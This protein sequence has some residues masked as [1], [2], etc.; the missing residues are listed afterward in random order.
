MGEDS[1]ILFYFFIL[2]YWLCNY[3]CPDFSA[4]APPPPST[5]HSLRPSPHHCSCP[6]VMHVS[7]LATSFPILYF[8]SPLLFSTYL[9]F[10]IPS[11]LHPFPTPLPSDNHQNDLCVHDSV[12]VL[13]CLFCFLDSVVDRYV[14][15]AILLFIVLIFSF[16]NKSC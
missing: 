4:F 1:G 5:L 3:S 15:I 11:L 8:I 10:L 14:F 2:F 7:S 13:V 6:W 9:Y 16:L 12:S